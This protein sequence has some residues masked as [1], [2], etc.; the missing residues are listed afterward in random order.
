MKHR[1]KKKEKKEGTEKLKT[2]EGGRR[3][4]EIRA[5][6]TRKPREIQTPD[7]A[8]TNSGINSMKEESIS[9]KTGVTDSSFLIP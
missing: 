3:R 7:P 5:M 6:K 9:L 4:E 8:S 1:R 2:K